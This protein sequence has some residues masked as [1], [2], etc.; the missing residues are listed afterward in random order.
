MAHA[1]VS[2]KQVS[3]RYCCNERRHNYST[4]K[5]FLEQL[6][7]YE[8]LL[9]K[10]ERELHL[11]HGRLQSGL[12]KLKTTASQV[13]GNASQESWNCVGDLVTAS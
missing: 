1:H 3:K 2:A 10:R 9:G 12:Q 13:C 8:S 7:L 4:P 5:S 11:R 6:R